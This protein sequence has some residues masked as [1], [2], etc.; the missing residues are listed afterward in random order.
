MFSIPNNN[1]PSF[2]P[3]QNNPP[4]N[5]NEEEKKKTYA[6]NINSKLDSFDFKN[7]QGLIKQTIKNIKFLF[8]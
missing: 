6:L 8:K 3:A 2:N 1:Q 5:S 4:Q 7:P